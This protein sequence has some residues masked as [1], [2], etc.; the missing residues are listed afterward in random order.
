MLTFDE[1]PDDN[2]QARGDR[3]RN[4]PPPP[5]SPSSTPVAI[6]DV[7]RYLG[8]EAPGGR[9]LTAED[10]LFIRTAEVA[11]RDF[12]IWSFNEPDGGAPAYVT[13]FR[14]ITAAEQLSAT[15]TTSTG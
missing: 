9:R 11:D 8:A 5:D 7:L 6:D 14:A 15:A 10:L 13:V 2:A 12:W 4:P 3:N 1:M